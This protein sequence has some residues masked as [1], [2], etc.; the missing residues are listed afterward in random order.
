MHRC[1]LCLLV[2]DKLKNRQLSQG[3][4]IMHKFNDAQ[5]DPKNL[6]GL[7]FGR[8]FIFSPRQSNELSWIVTIMTNHGRTDL[9][10]ID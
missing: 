3:C 10:Q 2:A 5:L 8:P 4:V 6:D 1:Q 7:E 9:G